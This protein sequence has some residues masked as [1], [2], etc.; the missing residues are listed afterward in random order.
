[1]KRVLLRGHLQQASRFIYEK[2][3]FA[4]DIIKEILT[5]SKL[6]D[7]KRL[8]E[9]LDE[10]RSRSRMRLEGASHSAAVAR[11]CSYF[12]PVRAFDD[13][14]GGIEY[15]HFLEKTADAYSKDEKFRKELVRKLKET[16][17]KLVC[18]R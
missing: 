15:F 18:S 1:M 13:M 9:I 3:G 4:F 7:E 14:T 12:S 5:A 8:G 2:V 10:M 11:A 17:E 6:D 16:A